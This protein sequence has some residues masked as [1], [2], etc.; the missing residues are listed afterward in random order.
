MGEFGGNPPRIADQE[1]EIPR[2]R[3]V[4]PYRLLEQPIRGGARYQL[5]VWSTGYSG[6]GWTPSSRNTGSTFS[7]QLGLVGCS[8][9]VSGALGVL[10]E[11]EALLYVHQ[12]T[13]QDETPASFQRNRI[14][15]CHE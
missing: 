6:S 1:G 11:G 8:Y 7:S 12:L 13:V 15:R 2:S 5:A 4:L 9:A 10:D 14:P 3:R